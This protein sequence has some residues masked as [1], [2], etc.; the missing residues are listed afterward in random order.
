M[1][2]KWTQSFSNVPALASI[3]RTSTS[4]AR[5]AVAAAVETAKRL[6]RFSAERVGGLAS[7]AARSASEAVH[8]AALAPALAKAQSAKLLAVQGA[9]RTGRAVGRAVVQS[10][11]TLRRQATTYIKANVD[12]AT[13]SLRMRGTLAVAQVWQVNRK[14]R[15]QP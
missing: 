5:K 14:I 13:E 15:R 7:D 4:E 1:P 9:Q 6:A 11:G 2:R 12:S 8:Q 3:R 10:G